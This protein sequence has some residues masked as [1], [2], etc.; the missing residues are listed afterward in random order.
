MN[1]SRE[2][3]APDPEGEVPFERRFFR[4]ARAD[5]AYLRFIVESYDGLV[6]L[7]TVDGRQGVVEV[8]C[9]PSCGREA[10]SLLRALAAETGLVEVAPPEGFPPL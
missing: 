9:H 1:E 8:S 7:R 10:E 6:F 4:I 5:M 2:N 3:M